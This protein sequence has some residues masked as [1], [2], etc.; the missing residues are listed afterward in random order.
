[1]LACGVWL[2]G[3]MVS[4]SQD[5]ILIKEV[6]SREIS[7]HAGGVQP[8]QYS[9]V[10]EVVSREVSFFVENGPEVGQSE[11]ISR[12]VSLLVTSDALPP[13]ITSIDVTVSPTGETVV[14]DWSA[15]NQWEVGDIAS[16]RIYVT[17][18]GPFT[19]VDDLAGDSNLRIIDVPGGST[20]YVISGLAA[21]TDHY[22][23][24]VPIDGQA[25][26]NYAPLVNYASSYVLSPEV[27][28][29][30]VALFVGGEPDPP[31]TEA[32][33]REV[34]LVI[35]SPGAP[36]AIPDFDVTVS[37]TGESAILDWTA[38]NQLAEADIDHFK[39]YATATGPFSNV[40]DLS[41]PGLRVFTVPG[42]ATSFEITDLT[43]WTDHYFAV[44]AVDALGNFDPTVSYGASYVLAPEAI[45]REMSLFVGGEPVPP[46]H[47][48]ISREI[49]IL[50]PDANIPAPVTGVD[51]GFSVTT[52][53]DEF[54]AVEMDW[55][56]YNEAGQLDVVRYRVYVSNAFFN[57]VAGM[58]PF[59]FVN[60]GQQ[61]HTLTG[62]GG[63]GIFHFAVVAEDAL[64][65][66]D[67]VVRSF[68]AQASVDGVGEVDNLSAVSGSDSLSFSWTEP[69]IGSGFLDRYRIYF[70]GST[71]PVEID[72]GNTSWQVSGLQ[73]ASGY[74]FRI[75]TVDHFGKESGGRTI[76]GA[77][78]LPN[79]AQLTLR[80]DGASVILDW[81]AIQPTSLVG[82]YAIYRES[83]PISDVSGLT[84]IAIRSSDSFLVGSFAQAQGDHFAVATVNISGGANPAVIS[85]AGISDTVG[86]EIGEVLL[87][88][89]LLE[90]NAI[91]IQ[92][93]HLSAAVTDE[94]G[95]ASV[96]FALIADSNG[97]ETVIRLDE[98]AID[99]FSTAL[100]LNAF[101]DGGYSLRVRAVDVYGNPSER[102]FPVSIAL[103]P[104]SAPTITSPTGAVSTQGNSLAFF[105]RATTFAQVFLFQDG[106]EIAGPLPLNDAG[107]FATTVG[108]GF[109]E[110]VY[111][112]RTRNRAGESADSNPVTIAKRPPLSLALDAMAVTEGGSVSGTVS[113]TQNVSTDLPVSLGTNRPS[114]LALAGAV[115]I[116]AGS[117]SASFVINAIQ[118][119]VIEATYSATISASALGAIGDSETVIVADD[120]WPVLTLT[121]SSQ[122]VSESEVPG[123]LIAHI[124]RDPVSMEALPIVLRT[125]D[126]TEVEEAVA[127]IPAGVGAVNLPV[128]LVDDDLIDGEQVVDLRAEIRIGG[129]SVSSNV[130]P[131]RVTDDEGPILALQAT[132]YLV[133]EGEVREVTVSRGGAATLTGELT[134]FLT[135][136]NG[137]RLEV[138]PSVA[139]P[140]GVVSQTFTLTGVDNGEPEGAEMIAVTA[141]ADGYDAAIREFLVSDEALA[142]L[143]PSNLQ[144]PAE[145]LSDEVF[146]VRYDL[147]NVG[148]A[149]VGAS[150]VQRIYLSED[151][152]A[153]GDLLVDQQIREAGSPSLGEGEPITIAVVAPSRRGEYWVVIETDFGNAVPELDEGNN[154]LVSSRPLRI[155]AAYEVTVAVDGGPFP[156]NTPIPLRGSATQPDG[157]PADNA[158]VAL[159]LRRG[160]SERRILGLTDSAGEF[161]V[162]WQPLPG[163][164]GDYRVAAAHPGDDPVTAPDQDTFTILTLETDFPSEPL[165]LDEGATVVTSAT[166]RNP[167]SRPLTG[168]EIEVVGGPPEL[169][170]S[171]TFVGGVN[172]LAP[173]ATAGVQLSV[174]AP[175]GFSGNHTVRLEVRT[176]D[177]VIIPVEVTIRVRP[178]APV[179]E[180]E[181]RQLNCSVLRGGQKSGSFSITNVG[182]APTGAIEVV[183]PGLEWMS[184]VSQLPLPSLAPGESVDFGFLL[185]PP[186]AVPLT[187]FE[188]TLLVNADQGVQKRVP[189]AFRVVSDMKGTL[190]VEVVDEFF[191][192]SEAK[193]KVEGAQVF[194]RDAL[195]G[196]DVVSAV[197]DATGTLRFENLMEGWYQ[198]EVTSPDH[199]NVKGNYY[200]DA[201]VVNR[202]QIFVSRELVRYTWTV[203]EIEIEDRYRVTV[204]STFQTNVPAPVVTVSP[205]VLELGDLRQVGQ[206]KVVN[207]TVENHGL[208]AAQNGEFL[209]GE[210]PYYK[211]T[212]LIEIVGTIPAKTSI[213]VPVTVERVAG[214]AAFERPQKL[215]PA[216]SPRSSSER[217]GAE[218]AV[219][220]EAQDVPCQI[221][222]GFRFSFLC[223]LIDVRKKVIIGVNGIDGSCGPPKPF[224]PSVPKVYDPLIRVGNPFSRIT[225]ATPTL[226]IC[227]ALNDQLEV[228]GSGELAWKIPEFI[229]DWVGNLTKILP[230][231]ITLDADE[232]GTSFKLKGQ[233]C[234]CCDDDGFGLDG[235]GSVAIE[236][237]VP[238][239]IGRDFDDAFETDFGNV[240]GFSDVEFDL[241]LFAGLK[242]ELVGELQLE[243]GWECNGES[244]YC[245]SGKLGLGGKLGASALAEVEATRNGVE[246]TGGVDFTLTLDGVMEIW[247]RGCC[248]EFDFASCEF[249]W[250]ACAKL[251]A[252]AA[253]TGQ[254]SN[255]TQSLE[256]G[257]HVSVDLADAGTC[258]EDAPPLQ[259]LPKAFASTFSGV[260]RAVPSMESDEESASYEGVEY[261][262]F[263]EFLRSRDEILALLMPDRQEGV[264]AEV[265]IRLDQDAVMTRSAFRATLDLENQQPETPLTDVAFDLDIRNSNGNPAD[266]H[267]NVRVTHLAGLG[268][269]DGTADIAANSTGTA[270]WTLIPRDTAAPLADTI[271]TVGGTIRYTLNGTELS[272]PVAEVPITVRPDA[273]LTLKYFHQRDVIADDPH[274]DPIEAAQP[275]ALAVMVENNGGGEASNLRIISGQPEIVENEKGLLIDFEVIGSQVEGQPGSTSLTADFGTVEPNSRKLATW[276]LT[277][278]LQGLF[279]DYNATFEHLDG[280]GDPK[281]SLIKGVQIH[282]TIRMFNALAAKEDGRPDFLVNDVPDVNDYPDTVHLSDGST[283]AVAVQ[284]AGNLSGTLTG[285]NL[286]LTLDVAAVTGWTYLRIPAPGDGDWVLDRVV[287]S[288][289]LEIPL[290]DSIS[291]ANGGLEG[292][293]NAWVSDRTFV[294]LGRRPVEEKILH[295][296]DFDST[297]R[298]A[299]H[300]RP[301][302]ASDDQVP[303]TSQVEMLPDANGQI[304]RV[305]WN[306]SDNVAL[307][308]FDIYVSVDGGP[309]QLWMGRT[310]QRAASYLGDANRH[311]AFFS[312]ATDTSGN[313]ESPPGGADASTT[314]SLTNSPP[315]IE[316]IAD[317]V[318][319]ENRSFS[320]SVV[321]DDPDNPGANLRYAI[322][323]GTPG[324]VIDE[325]TG[326][327][328]WAVGETDGGRSFDVT[329]RVTDFG[330]PQA[331]AEQGFR[332]TVT[333][334]NE[335]PVLEVIP[336]QIVSLGGLL[337]VN[338]RA[339]DSDD[340]AQAITF[341]LGVAPP[342]MTIGEGSGLISWVPTAGFVDQTVVAEVVADDGGISNNTSSRSFSIRV[343]DRNRERISFEAWAADNDLSP[344]RVFAIQDDDNDGVTL[345]DEYAFGLNP[346]ISDFRFFDPAN[347]SGGLPRIRLVEERLVIEFMRRVNAADLGY[348]P[349]FSDGLS[350]EIATWETGVEQPPSPVGSDWEQV[351]VDDTVTTELEDRRFGRVRTSLS[352]P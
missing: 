73:P 227:E 166:V 21:Y 237:K 202:R 212:P 253:A 61:M 317:Q 219:S 105:G 129:E 80:P 143:A 285:N 261:R 265:K 7:V 66:F 36:T 324:L 123:V 93:G 334:V 351:I 1:M 142:E 74:P 110:N 250:G 319:V 167:G 118:D 178:L 108:I 243:G 44:V 255:G 83:S 99:G 27:I 29:R 146:E 199:T 92:S 79:P 194:V 312:V 291:V 84:P 282:E 314:S 176:T 135:S 306:G 96:E 47:E 190:E 211:I 170:I 158:T 17:S 288:D 273:A 4:A 331:S 31:Y 263:N 283:A 305:S 103:Q 347:P 23:A 102:S 39:I 125:S 289:G 274:T 10:K 198:V 63:G 303:P 203:E 222:I 208:I 107:G 297:G 88:G 264:C 55:S 177:G 340:P 5:T 71:D 77:T 275:Y 106:V 310:T 281:I 180:I 325:D 252:T 49:S 238:V 3:L 293:G 154:V 284:E 137:N 223:G 302:T 322:V 94:W 67:P 197:T 330:F 315:L 298:Y 51:S 134:V 165:V 169:V 279:T 15:Y 232:L 257:G 287:R 313:T 213:V 246:Y 299:L 145:V 6:I 81:D 248:E 157:E 206:Q 89:T 130:V 307:A 215:L 270:Q 2:G 120:D 258:L 224:S 115:V 160:P 159:Y 59:A 229:S 62:L 163:E 254:L 151:P 153:G 333:E 122:T 210:H 119:E 311:Y 155:G 90:A 186:D 183:L 43:P 196:E 48:A 294:G 242:A 207:F 127:E 231:W 52:S 150:Y 209:F 139:I 247:A 18:T 42:G 104:P 53:V 290:P 161:A 326:R 323:S 16:F 328:S 112:A 152:V 337:V 268:A 259:N 214:P 156:A 191:F 30:E 241:D 91:L 350:S 320:L 116:Q 144:F 57:E 76:V 260:S 32:I 292:L 175:L 87:S 24:V 34:S 249:Q 188:G 131:L 69:L 348:S 60:A 185:A 11:T 251:S 19:N 316:P 266:E 97:A 22:F 171:P 136:A 111:T 147:E 236:I 173:G 40:N 12:E 101:A 109:G 126:P 164:G 148:A 342:G 121:L 225:F 82:H 300:Y 68:S 295:L 304:F 336:N 38:Y 46:Y 296:I 117:N 56:S 113:T 338:A 64:G 235:T 193:P 75:T 346:R 26:N 205:G 14:L 114:Q 192:F 262:K 339:S 318:A 349:E 9:G 181:P 195:S 162:A 28:S 230:S 343:V 226:C 37:P 271:Y 245:I 220:G 132:R 256:F 301:F 341:S 286:I 344:N 278:S 20:S 269:I 216:T 58:T 335:S 352:P 272:I 267:F 239:I 280:L 141:T 276:L 228:C 189:F 133:K 174:M 45:S 244:E 200:V 124:E 95:V 332:I 168:L 187:L 221:E 233:V 240:S 8:P 41:D 234:A 179:L 25:V 33:S 50:L 128:T 85:V 321:A 277:S 98:E 327:M 201:G 13:A 70:A 100:D 54:G 184:P 140:D 172:E 78:W 329:V 35:V 218:E 138:P 72:R 345:I 182:G 308:F 309:W 86:P 217:A 149:E 204:E 65:N